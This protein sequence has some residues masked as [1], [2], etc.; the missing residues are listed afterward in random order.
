MKTPEHTADDV[1]NE[2]NH[3]QERPPDGG[4]EDDFSG[5]SSSDLEDTVSMMSYEELRTEGKKRQ[6]HEKTHPSWTDLPL[7]TQAG[8]C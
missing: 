3:R 8:M 5:E 4:S 1:K 6:L 7:R 2:M